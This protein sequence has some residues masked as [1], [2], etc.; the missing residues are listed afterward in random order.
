M[1]Q[2]ELILLTN[3]LFWQRNAQTEAA[4]SGVRIT[5]LLGGYAIATL[6]E[7]QV[8]EFLQ[9]PGILY[10]ELPTRV[11]TSA[12]FGRAASCIN[13]RP[14]APYAPDNLSGRGVL[15][16]II[17]SGIDYA[18]PDFRNEDGTTR[19]A[20]LWDQSAAAESALPGGTLSAQPP[21]GYP[22]GVLYTGE[23][24]NAALRE[25]TRE[26]RQKLVPS[27]DLSGHGTHVAGIAAGNGRASEGRYRGVAFESGLLIVKLAEVRS[28]TTSVSGTARL[29]EAVDFCI[30]YAMGQNKP[31]ALNLSYGTAEGA[32]NGKSLLETYINTVVPMAKCVICVGTGNDGV[33]RN[34]A[35]GRL[36]ER[37]PVE[38]ELAIE[39]VERSIELELWKNYPD[40]FAVELVAP[41]GQSGRFVYGEG[42]PVT[43]FGSAFLYS[44]RGRTLRLGDAE[45]E[46][47]WSAPTIY[48]N[49]SELRI[50]ITATGRELG[51]GIWLIRLLPENIVEGTYDIWIIRGT[52]SSRS[53]FVVPDSYRTLTIPSTAEN[54]ISVGAY[55]DGTYQTAPFSGRGT[56][57]E[58][59]RM[60]PDL[61]APGVDITSC[62]PGGGYT[63]LSGT[64]MA[65]PFATGGAALLLQWGVAEGNDPFLYGEK[66]RE[67]FLK[68]AIRLPGENYP[69]PVNGWGRLCVND[70]IP[71]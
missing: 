27:V 17:D 60:K 67:Y 35:G 61:V 9:N 13:N 6:P 43:A 18:H 34:H 48:Q 54:V 10:A 71:G 21:E 31:L 45:V 12:E 41:N 33:G 68:G 29:M 47:L 70:S 30:R 40:T 19:I 63:S 16:G 49:L 8:E 26:N 14:T 55:D 20:A 53:G 59:G 65:T 51:V 36:T 62:A 23:Q 37:E 4:E 7:E 57:R 66:L 44:A 5:E 52:E 38:V 32:H 58:A 1:A 69:D 28:G 42:E 2:V 39:G 56:A 25:P 46:L 15:V 22:L 64:S 3:E 50:S 24:I 11:Y